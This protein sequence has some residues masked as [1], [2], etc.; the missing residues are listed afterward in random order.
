MAEI[1][2]SRR[3]A[4]AYGSPGPYGLAAELVVPIAT[5]TRQ[6]KRTLQKQ[7]PAHRTKLESLSRT[8]GLK[9]RDPSAVELGGGANLLR[10]VEQPMSGHQPSYVV[11]GMPVSPDWLISTVQR[12]VEHREARADIGRSPL[13]DGRPA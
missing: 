10:Y 8:I 9:L 3:R 6:T 4:R 2:R 12:Y 11:F 13:T 5:Q 1:K 7:L